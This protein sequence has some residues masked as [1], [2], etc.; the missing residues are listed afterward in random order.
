MSSSQC[1]YL[2][3]NLEQALMQSCLVME[4]ARSGSDPNPLLGLL[5]DRPRNTV[6]GVPQGLG[7]QHAR[8]LCYRSA[9]RTHNRHIASL[10]EARRDHRL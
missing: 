4:A 5:K 1:T 6:R 10:H 7:F 2:A 3:L 9:L 8:V